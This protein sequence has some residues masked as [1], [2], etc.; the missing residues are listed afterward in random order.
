MSETWVVIKGYPNYMISN[1]GRVWSRKKEVVFKNGAKRTFKEQYLSICYTK[2]GYC[3]VRLSNN[4]VKKTKYVHRLVAEHFIENNLNKP[5]VNHID[6]NKNNNKS[7]NLEWC[8]SKEN[9]IHGWKNRLYKS[10]NNM[11]GEK[12]GN[13]KLKEKDVL[14]IR[15]LYDNREKTLK[16]LSLL[17]NTPNSTIQKI[18][19]RKTWKHLEVGKNEFYSKI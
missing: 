12:H 4:G 7:Q 16:E 8:T 15:R 13:H 9:K 1:F 14:E 11:K 18:V 6:G 10:H 2:T 17:F 19:Y 5:E 3:I